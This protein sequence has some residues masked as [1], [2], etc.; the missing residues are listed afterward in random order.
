MMVSARRRRIAEQRNHFATARSGSWSVNN[1]NLLFDGTGVCV[2]RQSQGF[3]G[4]RQRSLRVD[5]PTPGHTG[6]NI[7]RRARLC[8]QLAAVVGPQ[9]DLADRFMATAVLER[10][11]KTIPAIS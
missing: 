11:E 10:P 4:K 6:Q 9:H 3:V 1:V 8:L 5:G 7:R 2:R